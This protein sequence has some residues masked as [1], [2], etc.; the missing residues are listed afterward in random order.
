MVL[1]RHTTRRRWIDRAI[2]D[3]WIEWVVLSK[4]DMGGWGAHC[5]EVF[6]FRPAGAVICYKEWKDITSARR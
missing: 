2:I 3:Y 6:Y 4:I 1:L 5:Q